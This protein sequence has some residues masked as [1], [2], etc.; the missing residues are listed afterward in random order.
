M[1]ILDVD[2]TSLL[3]RSLELATVENGLLLVIDLD[4]LRILV[5]SRK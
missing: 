5:E 2:G 4:D 3:A 1:R